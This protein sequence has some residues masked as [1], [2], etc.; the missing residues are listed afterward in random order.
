MS[1]ALPAPYRNPSTDLI[2]NLLFCDEPSLFAEAGGGGGSPIHVVLSEG[3]A[4]GDVRRIAEDATAESR[5]RLLAFNWLRRKGLPVPRRLFLGVVVE[6]HLEEGL[7]TLAAY[8]DS[9]VRLIGRMGNMTMVEDVPELLKE[10]LKGLLT[11]AEWVMNQIGPSDKPR[12]AEPPAGSVR[13]TFLASDGIYF[14]QGA[15]DG[16][17][18]D[19]MA[20]PVIHYATQLFQKLVDLT[21]KPKP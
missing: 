1:E 11:S 18:K 15:F 16:F 9:R 6:V 21:A 12:M 14:G 8:A 5:V 20:G 10:P 17:A 19:R 4:E 2:Y 7:D 3:S 13:L